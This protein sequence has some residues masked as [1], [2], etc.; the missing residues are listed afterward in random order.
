MDSSQQKNLERLRRIFL[1]EHPN[2]TPVYWDNTQTLN[3]YDATF[4]RRIAWKWNAVWAELRELSW[5]PPTFVDGVIDWGCGTGVASETF[6]T[7]FPDAARLAFNVYDHSPQAM[8]Y[9]SNKLHS[10]FHIASLQQLPQQTE[11]GTKILLVSHVLTELSEQSLLELINL[12]AK[13]AITV[14][15]EPGTPFCAQKLIAVRETLRHSKKIIAPCLHQNTCGLSLATESRDWCH[16]FAKPPTSIFHSSEWATF[17]HSIGIDLRSLPLSY[18]V[19]EPPNLTP[20]IES[21]PE[22][23]VLGRP[24]IQKGCAHVCACRSSGI[25]HEILQKKEHKDFLKRLGK[26]FFRATY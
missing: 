9:A 19:A 21:P 8:Q 20:Q 22:T 14:W 17:A 6:L 4:A 18:L 12:S 25:A 13:C 11:L 26:G 15:V 10:K 7:H 2:Q 1:E 5:Q 23:R 3:L 16:F 24:R